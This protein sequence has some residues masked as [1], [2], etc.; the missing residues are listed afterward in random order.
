MG[1]IPS[2]IPCSFSTDV[3]QRNFQFS[4]TNPKNDDDDDDD[5]RKLHVMSLSQQ[6]LLSFGGA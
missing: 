2:S 5:E 4:A 3:Q 1:P 6:L